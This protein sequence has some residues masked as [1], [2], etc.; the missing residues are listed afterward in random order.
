MT[1]QEGVK[2]YCI[3]LEPYWAGGT[4]KDIGRCV[5]LFMQDG[6]IIHCVLADTKRI[7]RSQNGEGK[8]GR[9]GE[10]AE[11]LC[12]GNKLNAAVKTSGT[13]SSLGGAFAQEAIE[14]W[15]HDSF[16]AGFGG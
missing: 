10:L 11:F 13:V 12:D 3:A 5:D 6:S 9:K 14:V 15:V 7:E 1:D 4:S 2:R 8:Y 16:I